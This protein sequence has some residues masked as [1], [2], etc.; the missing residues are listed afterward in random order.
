M[1]GKPANA[2]KMLLAAAIQEDD[3][4]RHL[5]KSGRRDLEN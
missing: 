5:W 2:Q 3:P 1:T 4:I